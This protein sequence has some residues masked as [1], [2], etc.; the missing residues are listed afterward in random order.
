MGI[1]DFACAWFMA[2]WGVCDLDMPHLPNV[3]AQRC[4][5]IPLHT[6]HMVDI[7]LI[8]EVRTVDIGKQLKRVACVGEG[9]V[10][11]VKDVARVDS[12]TET[13]VSDIISGLATTA[14][15]LVHS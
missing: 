3:L 11:S 15:T 6:L 12:D 5:E 14:A 2:L 9:E 1:M 10:G 4:D 7:I 8:L 13:S